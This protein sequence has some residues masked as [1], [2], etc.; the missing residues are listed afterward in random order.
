MKKLIITLSIIVICPC[1]MTSCRHENTTARSLFLRSDSLEVEEIIS[2]EPVIYN[3]VGHHGPAVENYASAFRLYFND[4][5]AIDVYSKSGEKMELME[6]LWYP[7]E[8]QQKEEGAGCDEYMVGKTVGLGG[9][10]LW[11]GEKEV[12]LVAESRTGRVGENDQHGSYAEIIA[13]GVEYKGGKVDIGMRIDV[14][15]KSRI[16]EVTAWELEGREVQFLTGVNYHPDSNVGISD[17][18]LWTWGVHPADVSTA[19][20]PIGAALFYSESQFGA[21]EM[22]SDML[23]IISKPCSSISTSI[24]A[25]STKE[26]DLGTLEAFKA[27]VEK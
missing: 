11:D 26:K 14:T 8:Q 22:T 1:L 16:A 27:F 5:G 20:I 23:R 19:P 13:Y 21:P 12:K 17:G 7:T 4:S 15:G 6:Y 18:V 10:A 2:P 25:A 3:K 24:L 9:I